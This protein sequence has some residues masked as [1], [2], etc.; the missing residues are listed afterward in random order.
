MSNNLINKRYFK[1]IESELFIDNIMLNKNKNPFSNKN[2]N[3]NKVI[4]SNILLNTLQEF[5][6]RYEVDERKIISKK[7]FI[8]SFQELIYLI[9]ESIIAQQ[10]I[11]TLIY[12]DNNDNNKKILNNIII[13]KA[14]QTIFFHLIKLIWTIT[15]L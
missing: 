1:E 6:E 14:K 5:I 3:N 2:I 9:R 4:K 15:L 10:K 13:Q 7:K 11:D 12:N 8:I